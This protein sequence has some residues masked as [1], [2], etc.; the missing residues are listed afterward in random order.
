MRLMIVDDHAPARDMIRQFLALPG[1]TFCECASG[2][3][4]LKCVREFKPHWITVDINMPGLDGFQCTEA[5]RQEHPSARIV[6][7]TGY[8]EPQYQQ[9]SREAGAVALINKEDLTALR[10]MLTREL[11]GTYFLPLTSRKKPSK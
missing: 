1:M 3:E 10:A 9:R 2:D 8:N 4:A 5:L 6:L 7:V 11:A